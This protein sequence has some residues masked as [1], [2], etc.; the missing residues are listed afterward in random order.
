MS[1]VRVTAM[2][3][4]LTLRPELAAEA[5]TMGADEL[6]ERFGLTGDE[7]EA[8]LSRRLD[9]LHDWGV[10][11]VTLMQFARTFRFS[12]AR[13]WAELAGGPSA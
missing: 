8:I 1:N 9:I 6:T 5:R 7:A 12:I 2:F 13:R 4:E 11:G 3:R 10:N